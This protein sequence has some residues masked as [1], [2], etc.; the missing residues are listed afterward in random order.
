M[1]SSINLSCKFKRMDLVEKL[2]Q[3]RAKHKSEYDKAC[4]VYSEELVALL[5]KNEAYRI[6]KD[7]V[8]TAK[9][10]GMSVTLLEELVEKWVACSVE[11]DQ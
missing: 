11:A 6:A 7:I 8:A 3:N 10:L 2:K 4:K 1:H 9:G 5:E